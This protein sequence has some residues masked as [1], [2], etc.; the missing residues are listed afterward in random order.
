VCLVGMGAPRLSLDAYR[1]SV[2]EHSLVGSFTYSSADF[3]D[4]AAWVGTAPPQAAALISRSVPLAEGP[5]AFAALARHDGTAGKV[6]VRLD[7]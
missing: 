5:A 6:L 1:I 7:R 2:D 4:A 3:A